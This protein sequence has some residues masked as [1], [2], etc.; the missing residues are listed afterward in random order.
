VQYVY[1]WPS[2]YATRETVEFVRKELLAN[3]EGLQVIVHSPSLR[4]T[5]RAL[6]LEFAYEPRVA[7]KDLDLAS[8]P[9]LRLLGV[10]GTARPTLLVV[11]PVGP[12]RQ[13]PDPSAW[14]HLGTR[15]LRAC[16]PDGGLCDDIYRLC[17]GA[18]CPHLAPLLK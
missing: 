5:W 11:S 6:G 16:K 18:S 17:H 3:P 9:G 12:A 1:G 7:L 2:G 10:W 15:V 14:A 8:A 13:P 4:T